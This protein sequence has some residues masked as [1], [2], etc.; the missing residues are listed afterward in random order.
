MTPRTSTRSRCLPSTQ[1]ARSAPRGSRSS[2]TSSASSS[3]GSG[4]RSGFPPRPVRSWSRGSWP[5]WESAEDSPKRGLADLFGED[6]VGVLWLFELAWARLYGIVTLEVFG[7]M[8]PALTVVRRDVPRGRSSRSAPASAWP[9]SGSGCAASPATP[10]RPTGRT[11]A[12][13]RYADWATC[14]PLGGGASGRRRAGWPG[15]RRRRPAAGPG[16]RRLRPPA[17]RG[18]ARIRGSQKV[19]MWRAMA[20]AAA[21]AGRCANWRAM[22]LPIRASALVRRSSAVSGAVTRG[23]TRA[24]GT[25]RPRRRRAGWRRRPGRR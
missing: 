12:D 11:S 7:H 4:S 8:D 14:G 15:G 21:G 20:S 19:S 3:S 6:G 5:A 1:A 24:R 17:P 22:S 9:T 23:P 10:T 16:C 25:R 13:R 18:R 2:P